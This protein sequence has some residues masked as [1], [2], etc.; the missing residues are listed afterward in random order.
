M[1]G[2]DDVGVCEQRVLGDRLL[3]EHVERRAGDLARVDRLAQRVL[4][5]Q[6]AARDVHDAHAVL[7]LR[8]GLGVEPVLGL[9]SDR[10]VD[11][12][13]VRLRVELVGAARALHAQLAE[14][15]LRH[16]GVEGHHAHAEAERALGDQ[17]A[18]AAEAE[19]AER[20]LVQLHPAELGAIPRPA[21]ERAVRLRHLAHQRQQHRERVLGR[22]D[23]VRLRSVRD[24]HAALGGGVDVDVV[25]PHAGPAHDLEPVRALDQVAGQL[26]GG[27]DQDPVELADAAVQLAI[28]PVDAQLDIEAR[29]AQQLH[30][31]LADLLLDEDLHV[32]PATKPA[33]PPRGKRAGRRR[34]RH[35]ARARSRARAASSPVRPS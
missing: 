14:A 8:E 9:R 23:H 10:Q 33:R 4:H 22:G 19:H 27:P 1:R 35:P 6:L 20:L 2:D 12:D 32:R 16:V 15:L 24:H 17:L 18:D 11:R 21:G 25:H 29:V 26:R 5:Q 13:E 31:G 30:A 7:H 3:P 28:V 34:R